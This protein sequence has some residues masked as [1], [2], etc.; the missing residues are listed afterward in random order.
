MYL[1]VVLLISIL[2]FELRI[3]TYNLQPSWENFSIVSLNAPFS[4]ILFC[5]Y[6][7]FL[8]LIFCDILWP[9]SICL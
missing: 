8:Y 5:L 1:N 3:E 2:P 7:S 6:Q 9:N 4:N